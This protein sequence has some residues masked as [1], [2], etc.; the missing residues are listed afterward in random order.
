MRTAV[1][2]IIAAAIGMCGFAMLQC[3]A[4]RNTF[5]V[6]F[7][8]EDFP[9]VLDRGA[10]RQLGGPLTPAE[11]DAIKRTSRTELERA[12]AGLRVN[13]TEDRR[14]FWRIKVVSDVGAGLRRRQLPSAG[15]ARV[16]GPLGGDASVGFVVLGMT[17]LTYAPPA[18]VRQDI[19]DGIGRGIGRAAAHEL[20]HLILG[21]EFRDAADEDSYEYGSPN[22]R[23]QYYGVLH[24]TTAWPLLQKK[25][26]K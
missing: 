16:L 20:G 6:G 26:G 4:P 21:G 24:W 8:Y 7:W 2:V 19:I 25:I 17:A 5:T 12:V 18:A 9:M 13:V 11:I 1:I 10:T 14:A 22:R 3:V 15:E 23:S